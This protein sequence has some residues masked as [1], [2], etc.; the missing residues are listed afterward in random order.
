MPE[1]IG[2]LAAVASRGGFH[3]HTVGDFDPVKAGI[4]NA[5]E[6]T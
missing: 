3:A 5:G 6:R 1:E 2:E 4:A